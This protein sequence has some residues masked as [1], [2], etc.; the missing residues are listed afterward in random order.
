MTNASSSDDPP[1]PQERERMILLIMKRDGV[2][3]EEAEEILR[4]ADAEM[5]RM[6][7]S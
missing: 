4:R 6:R 2:S 1:D 7:D 3:R 5:L